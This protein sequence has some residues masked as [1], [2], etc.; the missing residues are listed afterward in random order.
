MG[1]RIKILAGFLILSA[2]LLLA[3]LWSIHELN[4]IGSSVQKILD[5]NYRSIRAAKTMVEAVEREDS[6]ILLLQLGKWEEGRTILNS[7]DSLFLDRLRFAMNNI[8][9]PGEAD[10]LQQI[11]QHYQEYKKMWERPIVDTNKQ[12]NIN[13]Y[14]QEVHGSFLSLKQALSDLIQ[15]NDKTLYRTASELKSRA[16]RAIMPGIIAIIAALV[17]SLIFNYLVNYFMVSPI[18]RI[19]DRIKKFQEKRTPFNVKIETHDEI[20]H[21]AEAI[22]HLCD[23]LNVRDS[24]A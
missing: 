7:A 1:L 18:I 16:D 12:G 2:M 21:L 6:A 8:T 4:L 24:Q 23:S 11:S 3:G 10:H 15:L 22:E 5:E 17:F 9:I 19:T 20:A 14:L 13:W